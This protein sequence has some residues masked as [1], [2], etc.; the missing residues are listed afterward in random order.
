MAG[1]Y[2]L[3]ASQ[4]NLFYSQKSITQKNSLI[5]SG[6]RNGSGFSASSDEGVSFGGIAERLS[7]AQE[8]KDKMTKQMRRM[9][10][11]LARAQDE[12]QDSA[13]VT[14]QDDAAEEEETK[15]PVRY[16]YKDVSSRIQR[17]KT[18]TSAGQAV[19][20]AKRKVLEIKRRIMSGK[21]DPEELQSVLTH[22][23]RME[24]VARKKKHHLELEEMV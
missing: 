7:E 20:S 10:R 5:V 24:M 13:G 22:A 15:Q 8:E 19:L 14:E 1:I 3:S 18:S 2:G 11:E 17:A 16:N 9:I 6:N 21:G 12:K 23:K 4:Q